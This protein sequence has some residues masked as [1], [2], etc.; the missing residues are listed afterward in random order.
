MPD[1]SE[2]TPQ[3]L[4]TAIRAVDALGDERPKDMDAVQWETARVA[5]FEL[6]TAFGTHYIKELTVG[7]KVVHR[8]SHSAAG[9]P[10]DPRP[11]PH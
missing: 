11:T 3:F 7:G 4:T 6:F 10:P 5:W 9:W 1:A 8:G 2:L